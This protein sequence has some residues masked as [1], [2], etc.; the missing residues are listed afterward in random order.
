MTGPDE[1]PTEDSVGQL[2]SEVSAAI[3]SNRR[4]ADTNEKLAL[5]MVEYQERARKATERDEAAKERD[6]RLLRAVTAGF[7]SVFVLLFAGLM[8]LAIRQAAT[9]Q[10]ARQS[11]D[12]LLDCVTRGGSCQQVQEANAR[13]FL[14]GTAVAAICADLHGAGTPGTD[15]QRARAAE[16]CLTTLTTKLGG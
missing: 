5:A 15:V 13:K 14:L 2:V 9:D 4:V 1:S 7:S 8:F 10:A 11:R 16:H 6:R 12:T 3:E